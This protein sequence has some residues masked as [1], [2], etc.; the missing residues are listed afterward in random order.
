LKGNKVS[1]MKNRVVF[2]E[3]QESGP[4]VSGGELV[5]LYECACDDY[6]PT[7]RDVAVLDASAHKNKVTITI[8]NAYQAFKPLPHHKFKLRS[9][10][11]K[12]EIF[13]IKN[14]GPYSDNPNF[15][16]IVGEGI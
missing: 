13:E 2:L 12:D 11:F 16:K 5:E 3:E 7:L 15:L 9:G 14:V 10:Y 8:R 4:E 1:L 6:E